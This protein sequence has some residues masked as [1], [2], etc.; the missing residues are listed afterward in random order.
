MSNDINDKWQEIKTL[1]E[2]IDLDDGNQEVLHLPSLLES[3]SNTESSSKRI[4]NSPS[5]SATVISQ[6]P[7]EGNRRH[8]HPEWDEWWFILE[9]IWEYEVDGVTQSVKKG[10]VVFIERQRVHKITAVG[11]SRAIRLAVSRDRV[12]HVY[13]G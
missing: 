7:G 11:E 2:S 8:Y 13:P 3:L 12:P 1:I 9:G 4:I 5:N 6:M 10:D